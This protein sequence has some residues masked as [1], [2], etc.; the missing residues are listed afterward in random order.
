MSD[1]NAEVPK[2][3]Q[4]LENEKMKP[5]DITHNEMA[6]SHARYLAGGRSSKV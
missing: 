3:L 4:A 1:P 5:I 6:K 2:I